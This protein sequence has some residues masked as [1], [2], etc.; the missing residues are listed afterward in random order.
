[1]LGEDATTRRLVIHAGQHKTGSTAIQKTLLNNREKLAA[2]GIHYPEIGFTYYGHH[3]IVEALGSAD[4]PGEA[5]GYFRALEALDG[6]V[7]IS[8][9]NFCR[10]TPEAI[11]SMRGLI[12][13]EVSVVLYIRNF[14]DVPYAWWQEEVKHGQ[15]KEFAA[16]LAELLIKP[17]RNHLLGVSQTIKR[18][19]EAFGPE[20]L[21]LFLYEE[22]SAAGEGD[23]SVQF[24]Q[25]ILG[26]TDQ[27]RERG[28]KTINKSFDVSSAELIRLLNC[29]GARG[30]DILQNRPAAQALR[31]AI[32]Q[33]AASYTRSITIDYD[34]LAFRRLE[35]DLVESWGHLI[36]PRRHSGETKLFAERSA[37]VSYLDAVMWVEEEELTNQL[38]RLV[39]R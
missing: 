18:Y 6:T 25:E 34:S 5:E 13:R 37:T 38:R 23:V 14:L 30:I 8:S 35:R 15:K 17:Y 20:A 11:A 39:A 2:R 4:R 33:K 24:M 3:K 16:F 29:L 1:M 36:R 26:V 9:E 12:S 28:I 22:A 31:E 19:A 32:R 27:E 21:T 7:V 10:A